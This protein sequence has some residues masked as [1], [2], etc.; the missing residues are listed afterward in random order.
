M[1]D[2][3]RRGSDS[4][5][6]QTNIPIPT[7]Q[8]PS[9]AR[10][11]STTPA[12]GS[13]AKPAQGTPGQRRKSVAGT[14]VKQRKQSGTTRTSSCDTTQTRMHSRS[15]SMQDLNKY[16][17]TGPLDNDT[18][19]MKSRPTSARARSSTGAAERSTN[20]ATSQRKISTSQATRNLSN[21][22]CES[23][24][25]RSQANGSPGNHSPRIQR[26]SSSTPR[27]CTFSP[28]SSPRVS[29]R[30]SSKTNIHGGKTPTD[31]SPG[32]M[33]RAISNLSSS[34][35]TSYRM[36]RSNSFDSRNDSSPQM[37][38]KKDYLMGKQKGT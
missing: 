12:N 9:S 35:S 18:R 10:R 4:S 21:T 16:N 17:L 27:G 31:C 26:R 1:Q 11:S 6:I 25:R 22:S 3:H 8:R 2:L 33:R 37:T 14:T 32:P 29:R 13:P 38:A 7:K 34:S 36:K 5:A 30:Q 23:P 20:P 19:T 15:R 28:V 24:R